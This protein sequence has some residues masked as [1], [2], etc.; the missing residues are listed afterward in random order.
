MGRGPVVHAKAGRARAVRPMVFATGEE[1][2]RGE[3]LDLLTPSDEERRRLLELASRDF[4]QPCVVARFAGR[5]RLLPLDH[6]APLDGDAAV[7]M[8]EASRRKEA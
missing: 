3:V 6:L 1:I 4:P 7:T 5:V 2:P 8:R